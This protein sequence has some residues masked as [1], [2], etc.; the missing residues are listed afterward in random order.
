MSSM[1]MA[2]GRFAKLPRTAATTL[3][4]L[5]LVGAL[6]LGPV[7]RAAAQQC[8]S[9]M[10]CPPEP[11]R[12][13]YDIDVSQVVFSHPMTVINQQ[14]RALVRQRI[15][16][17]MEPQY[18][19]Y[20]QLLVE[21]TAALS[22][23]PDPPP[24]LEIIGGTRANKNLQVV[25]PFLWKHCHAAYSL[26]L[27][28]SY[29]DDIAYAEK[30]KEILMAWTNQDTIFHG[31]GIAPA[32]QI[33]SWFSPMLYAADLIHD[34]PGWSPTERAAFEAWW[35]NRALTGTNLM[36][37][38]LHKSNNHKDAALLG[39]MAAAVVFEDRDLLREALINLTSYFFPRTDQWAELS[40]D[41]P[42]PGADWKFAKDAHG[43]YLPREVVR[44]NGRSGVSYTGYALTTMVQ[45]LEI[46]RYA[47][48]NFWHKTAANGAILKEVIQ[49]YFDWSIEGQPFP[50]YSGS[51]LKKTTV[52]QNA[53][54]VANNHFDM[55]QNL[56]NWLLSTGRPLMGKQGDEYITLNKGDIPP[57]LPTR[58]R[59]SADPTRGW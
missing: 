21:A 47:G 59:P 57:M 4:S 6:S 44:S 3:G 12:S 48:F 11:W 2:G 54:E 7:E 8:M 34:Y 5:T 35:R 14:E 25:R 22:F 32:L 19:A 24:V 13:E 26:A 42:R 38:A 10:Q 52:R 53:Y 36:H 55:G 50:W 18:S 51:D 40:K 30:A 16:A 15:A 23:I 28:Y 56:K 39:I 58:R 43:S 31:P 27:A 46:A 9:I 17:M 1:I 37:S 33:G 41:P 45:N 29:S 49:N 20:Q